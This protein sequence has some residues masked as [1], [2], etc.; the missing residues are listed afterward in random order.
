MTLCSRFLINTI[1]HECHDSI[2]S[3]HISEDRTIEKVKNCAWLSSW[4]KE[5]I[6][7]FNTCDRLQKANSSTGK[8]FGLMIHIQNPKSPWEAV[9]MDWVT[10]L[11]PSGDKSY[12]SF[13]VIIERYNKAPIVLPI[14]KD[15][16]AMDLALL[17]LKRV[18]S[19]TGLFKNSISDRE[20]KLKFAL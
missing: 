15:E 12:N 13:L 10:V 16:T 4:R 14:H 20:P 17:L 9:P 5:T 11:P 18:I 1:L 8:K 3:G 2:Y 7:Y 19:H 6:Q